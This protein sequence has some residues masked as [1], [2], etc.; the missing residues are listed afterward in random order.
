MYILFF[1]FSAKK[2][3]T[4]EILAQAKQMEGPPD[5]QTENRRVQVQHMIHI[6]TSTEVILVDGS[7]DMP[8]AT[9]TTMIHYGE[10]GNKIEA[11]CTSEKTDDPFHAEATAMQQALMYVQGQVEQGD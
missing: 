4:G 11:K 1:F 2:T 8:N 7:W 9:G 10:Q 6:P 3:Q 5:T